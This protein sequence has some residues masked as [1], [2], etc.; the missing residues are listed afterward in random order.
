MHVRDDIGDDLP[1][2]QVSECN[3][4]GKWMVRNPLSPRKCP[5]ASS[6]RPPSCDAHTV[7]PSVLH[8][9]AHNRTKWIKK[10]Y[11]DPIM[12]RAHLWWRTMIANARIKCETRPT[13][14]GRA[15]NKIGL[16][17]QQTCPVWKP[18]NSARSAS[19]SFFPLYCMLNSFF[20][21]FILCEKKHS[22]FNFPQ[23][24]F[25]FF[26]WS[27]IRGKKVNLFC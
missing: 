4:S 9:G 26:P 1:W 2:I 3:L 21:L 18:P 12:H 17:P 13:L 5:F 20:F 6:R 25:I 15:G 8:S 23:V 19:S 24:V 22:E 10:Q 27:E 7:N 14:R 16:R 11:I